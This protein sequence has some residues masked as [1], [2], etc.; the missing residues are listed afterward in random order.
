M[1]KEEVT[2]ANIFKKKYSDLTV[3]EVLGW[4]VGAGLAVL[5]LE[6]VSLR[7]IDSVKEDALSTAR[8]CKEKGDELFEG[9]NQRI[10]TFKIDIDLDK[11]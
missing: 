8:L 3:G 1:Q 5:A 9:F 11:K 2:M 4:S 6:V 10:K 7:G